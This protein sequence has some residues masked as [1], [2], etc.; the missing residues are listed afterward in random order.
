MIHKDFE[1]LSCSAVRAVNDFVLPPQLLAVA[2][3]L[4]ALMQNLN[5]QRHRGAR[6][7]S[8]ATRSRQVPMARKRAAVKET[9]VNGI[10][11]YETQ[12][13]TSGCAISNGCQELERL[14]FERNTCTCYEE[15]HAL[16][17]LR[18]RS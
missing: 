4:G 18:K 16:N 10:G 5:S 2:G 11:M 3:M 8:C 6:F 13:T 7:P 1:I 9:P 14:L 17:N 12:D 15:R